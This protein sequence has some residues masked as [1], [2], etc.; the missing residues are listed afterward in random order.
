M[1]TIRRIGDFRCNLE[2]YFAFYVICFDWICNYENDSTQTRAKIDILG[3]L[4]SNCRNN[5]KSFKDFILVSR[6]NNVKSSLS[7]ACTKNIVDR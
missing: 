4:L 7:L 5:C 1:E 3:N 6:S 2:N